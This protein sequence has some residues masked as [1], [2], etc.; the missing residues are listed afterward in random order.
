MKHTHEVTK[1]EELWLFILQVLSN[2]QEIHSTNS[3]TKIHWPAPCLWTHR[4]IWQESTCLLLC[5]SL[6]PWIP[7]IRKKKSHVFNLFLFSS[8]PWT[9]ISGMFSF[10]AQRHLSPLPRPFQL[11]VETT[12]AT[13]SFLCWFL[14]GILSKLSI[15]YRRWRIN[16]K[17]PLAAGSGKQ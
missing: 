7:G 2:S 13:K 5:P 8:F 1:I 4:L 15:I 12:S 11:L 14:C 17:V 3:N 16:S 9:N 10:S 6:P